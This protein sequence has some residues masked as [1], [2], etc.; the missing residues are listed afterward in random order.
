MIQFTA[1]GAL[2]KIWPG[3]ILGIAMIAAMVWLFWKAQRSP[4]NPIDFSTMF[5]WPQTQQTSV[6]IFLTFLA[7]MTGIWVIVDMEFRGKLTAEIFLGFLTIMIFGKGATEWVNAWRDKPAAPPPPTQPPAQQQFIGKADAVNAM[8]P[9]AAA[10][11]EP[12]AAHA[13]TEVGATPSQPK[14]SAIACG[15]KFKT[16]GKRGR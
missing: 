8:P 15:K 4:T 7:G 9:A 10:A 11:A 13:A 3:Q 5:V 6:I 16:K 2:V 12:A 1:W 14:R